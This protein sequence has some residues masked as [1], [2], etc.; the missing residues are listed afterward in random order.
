MALIRSNTYRELLFKKCNV[1]RVGPAAID[2]LRRHMLT[3]I[4][5]QVKRVAPIMVQKFD[6][7]EDVGVTYKTMRV[8][9]RVA[10]QEKR[11]PVTDKDGKQIT[12][13]DKFMESHFDTKRLNMSMKLLEDYVIMVATN[14]RFITNFGGT[15]IRMTLTVKDMMVAN[16]IDKKRVQ[17]LDDGLAEDPKVSFKEIRQNMVLDALKKCREELEEAINGGPSKKSKKGGDDE[18]DDKDDDKDDDEEDDKEDDEEDDKDDDKE[19]D[20]DDDKEDDEEDDKDDDEE[21]DEEDDKDE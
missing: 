6:Y 2:Y 20:E 11:I 4:R 10:G 15:K 3:Y 18:E 14:G 9:S 19:D 1:T 12:M 17:S 7:M 21:D 16:A 8:P 5:A 13:P